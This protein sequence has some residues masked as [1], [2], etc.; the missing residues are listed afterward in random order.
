MERGRIAPAF[1]EEMQGAG[2]RVKVATVDFDGS[3]CVHCKSGG[4]TAALHMRC[5]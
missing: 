4:K 1:E 3:C 5:L 2:A